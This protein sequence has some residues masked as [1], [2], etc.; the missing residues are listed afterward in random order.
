MSFSL[1][2]IVAANCSIW[3]SSLAIIWSWL[4]H[5]WAWVWLVISWLCMNCWRV[6]SKDDFLWLGGTYGG[7]NGV[8]L[9]WF[10]LWNWLL[11][12]GHWNDD[13]PP[14]P[15][16]WGDFYERWGWFCHRRLYLSLNGLL[17][18]LGLRNVLSIFACS[19]IILGDQSLQQTM[20]EFYGHDTYL[21]HRYMY[22]ADCIIN[23]MGYSW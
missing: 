3:T 13:D 10:S 5:I 4:W 1:P 17:L 7:T 6:S 8:A 9:D 11:E 20:L 16:P 14:Y 23:S 2:L 12:D 19:W 15:C 22:I 21:L 18:G